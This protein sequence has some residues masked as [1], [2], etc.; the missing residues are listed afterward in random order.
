MNKTYINLLALLPSR[1]LGDG[2]PFAQERSA[3]L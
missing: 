1:V 2:V 3:Q